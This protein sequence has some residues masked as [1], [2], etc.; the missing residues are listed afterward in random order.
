M[1]AYPMP[2]S[3]HARQ[4]LFYRLLKPFSDKRRARRMRV[5]AARMNIR[6]DLR[7]LDLG[8]TSWIWADFDIPLNITFINL[9]HADRSPK[10]HPLHTFTFEIG[11][12]CNLEKFAD[13]SFDVVF[14]NS[15]IEHVGDGAKR[16]AFAAEARRLA[17]AYWIQT[18]AKSFPIEAHCGMPF[19]WYY[20]EPW[21]KYFIEKW[22]VKLPL[23]TQ[24]V[25][26]TTYVSENELNDLFDGSLSYSERYCGLLKS[27][28]R[29]IPYN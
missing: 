11:D 12:A 4:K 3:G 26:E 17:N 25:E 19:W 10:E 7:V 13:K 24:M 28:C 8:G 29:F 15:V 22:K 21:R 27:N 16:K 18:P 2:L 5:F 9:Q 14:S 1:R 23:W 20:S 6:P